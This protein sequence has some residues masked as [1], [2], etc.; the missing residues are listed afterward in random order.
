[1]P[2]SVF[3]RPVDPWRFWPPGT[4]VTRHGGV[5]FGSS[6]IGSSYPAIIGSGTVLAA[7]PPYFYDQTP[8]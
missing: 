4:L 6:L 7:T 2:P 5:L 3:P 1:M 8:S